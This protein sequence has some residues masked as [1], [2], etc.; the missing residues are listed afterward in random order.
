MAQRLTVLLL[1]GQGAQRERMAA[2]LYRRQPDFTARADELFGLL[3]PAGERLAGQWLQPAPNPALGDAVIA[4]PLLLI[5]GYALGSAV[6]ATDLLLGHSAGELAAACLAG[7]FSPADLAVAVADR[8]SSLGH[9]G[10]GG[11]LAVAAGPGD[12]AGMLE[13]GVAVAAVNGPRQTVVAGPESG[14]QATTARLRAA[15]FTVRSLRSDHAFHNAVMQP[16]ANRFRAALSRLELSVPRA[17]VISGRTTAPV[18]AEQAV[19]PAFWADQLA[20]P[21]YYWPALRSLLNDHGTEPGLVLLDASA[22]CSLSAAAQRHPAVRGGTSIVVPLLG[23]PLEAG[24]PAD[25]TAF[26][27]AVESLG[28]RGPA[29]AGQA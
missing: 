24:G 20:L 16:A 28:R 23:P 12:L 9:E 1:P 10:R 26:A 18:T 4:Q 14:L 5:T 17:T 7:V 3:G 29:R 21:V 15:G 6:G 19:D 11:M 27:A 22:D 25:V 13:P 8:A 2:G